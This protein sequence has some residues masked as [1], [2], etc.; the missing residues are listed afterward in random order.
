MTGVPSLSLIDAARVARRYGITVTATSLPSE[1]DQNL[2]LTCDDGDRFI[3]KLANAA[4]RL[5]VLE[6]ENAVLRHLAGTG[7]TPQLMM[8]LDGDAITQHD[9]HFVRLISAMPGSTLGST[10]FQTAALRHD[11]GRTLGELDVALTTCDQPAFHRHFHWDLAQA[12]DVV[13][14]LLPLLAGHPHRALVERFAA[15][16]TTHVVPLL[17]TFRRSLI[18]S[19]ANDYNLLVDGA[20]QRVTGVVDFGDMVH[21]HTVNEVAIAMA[22]AALNADDP[23]AAAADVACGYHTANPLTDAEISALWSLMCMRL[24][25][26]A[27]MAA[28]QQADRPGDAYL[29]ISQGPIAETLP[30]LAA[31]HPRFAHYTFR[32]ACGLAPVPHAPR[33]VDWISA[34]A[35]TFAPLLGVDLATT[36]VAPLDFSAGSTLISSDPAANAPALLDARIAD[37][38]ARHGATIGAGG[39]DE[40]R[41]IYHWPHEP[42]DRE[43][44]TIH[45]GLD[46]SLAA[47][48]PLYAP[49]EGVVHGFEDADHFHDYGPLIVLR[50]RT[51]HA[52]P[53]EFFT[54]YGHLTRDSLDGLHVGK[55]IARGTEFARIGSAPTN[56]HWWAH[57]HVQ[58]ATDLL[59]VPCNVD[60]AVRAS[61]RAVWHS[62]FPDPN[63]FLRI[64]A[65]SLPRHDVTSTIADS[66]AAHIGRNL[67][68]SYGQAPLHVVRGAGQ[69]LYDANAHRFIDAYNN[70]AHVGHGH[71]RVVQAVSAQLALLNTNTRYLQEQLTR[72]AEQLTALLPAPLSVCYFTASGSE[73]NE[74]ALRL[75]RAHTGARDLLVMDAAYHGHTTTLID[76]S[77]YKHAGPGGLGA[78]G[79]VHVTP[80]PDTYRNRDVQGDPG[81]WFAARVGDAIER[82]HRA[83]RRVSG[84]IAETC[85][86]VAGQ[87][88]LPPGFLGDVYARVRAAGGVCIADEVQTGFGR[89]GTHFW[90]FEAHGVT[91]DI[92]VLGKPIANGFPMGAV[93]T[94][95]A[96]ADAFDNGMEYFSTFGGSTAAC[97]AAAAT[98][99]VTLDERLQQHAL[100]VGAQLLDGLRTLQRSHEIIGDVR[101]SGLFIG[102]ELVRDRTTREPAPGEASFVVQRMRHRGV[103][104]GTDGPHH[105]VIK[106]RGPMT[107]GADDADRIVATMAM[108]LREVAVMR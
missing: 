51:D 11:I 29:G 86:S 43:P 96:I 92:V 70:V 14:D 9:G 74:L 59:D 22:Y 30:V 103:L 35:H 89:I 33:I 7:R 49:L 73:A 25:V 6:A 15:Q 76:I 45:I 19:D 40:A 97:V 27:C 1:R 54:F 85:P 10:P 72:Y 65:V 18:H 106:I 56:G 84:Y 100:T 17:P 41:L 67:S 101:G 77:P 3:L 24:C 81:P 98:L 62:V 44:R 34:H 108:A 47:R 82:V 93:I 79:W 13:R 20:A 28:K 42:K 2:L 104:A 36:P 68:L 16:H 4:E 31:I 66:R 80:I 57:V 64:P 37:V 60:G 102:V 99:Q 88:M 21:S 94:S 38:L 90:A 87:I 55:A 63:C 8:T 83:G 71:P 52:E 46:L 95:R 5:D 50:H 23:L 12:G 39:Y 53:L 32:H 69:Y 48:S 61:Q 26:S 78:P 105:N 107:L 58:L 75:A 91:P